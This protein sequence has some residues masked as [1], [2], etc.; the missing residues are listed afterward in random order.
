MRTHFYLLTIFTLLLHFFATRGFSQ[1]DQSL[2]IMTFNIRLNVAS[3][4]DN[5]WPNRTELVNSM[6]RF[7][8][9]DIVG[10]QEA[11]ENQM[12]DLKA[13]LPD[14]G[15]HGV[16]RDTNLQWGEYSAIFYR[17]SR[18][19][20]LEG[21]TFWLSESPS[22]ASRG[23]DAALN[24][25]VTWAKFEDRLTGK[26]FFHFNTHFDHRGQEARENSARLILDKIQE[27]NP[28]NLPVIL[29]GDFN[30]DPQSEP[31][32]IL[33]ASD[34]GLVMQDAFYTSMI[35]HHGPA[36]T[37][38]GFEFPGIED[39]R[40]DYIFTANKLLVLKHAILSDSWSGRYPSDHLPVIAE[41]MIDPVQP[42]PEAH[43]HND[44]EHSDP[45]TGA[46]LHGFTSFEADIWLI[47]NELYLSHNRPLMVSGLKT[48]EEL[49]L[50]PLNEIAFK[51]Y[52]RIFPGYEEPVQLMID[53]KNEGKETYQNLREILKSYE[54]LLT[55]GDGKKPALRILISGDRPKEDI[56]SDKERLVTIDGR[57]DDLGELYDPEIMPVISQRFGLATSWKGKS[58]VS[59]SERE[60]LA[61]L[62]EQAHRQGKKVRLWATPEDEMVWETL[63]DIG[64]DY[65]N[66]DD[67]PRLQK[68]LL[69]R[70]NSMGEQK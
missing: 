6:I 15:A 39:R 46:L 54:H 51:N 30:A 31:Y 63:L 16:A 35:P 65:I 66:T 64:I 21:E 38:S 62:V 48:L 59:D 47:N 32:K 14:F 19:E 67:R 33:T 42:H 3:D 40:I 37:W 10:V 26:K 44:Y 41:V 61:T 53:F 8:Q 24:R 70:K 17:R 68:F 4:G 1:A 11:L 7:H 23:W 25:I 56:I 34:S 29:T 13:M 49:Y 52:G 57:P 58:P 45:L 12:T 5:A 2:R 55:E 43:A 60:E 28:D 9:A 69:E 50:K 20:L 22:M 18:F 27:Y 36:S